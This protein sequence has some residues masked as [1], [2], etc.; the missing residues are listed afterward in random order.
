MTPDVMAEPRFDTDVPARFQVT[1]DKVEGRIE[2]A[3]LGG[4]FIETSSIPDRGDK[5]WLSFEGPDG[6]VVE[7]IG[8]VWWTTLESDTDRTTRQGF[9]VRLVASSGD[10]RRFMKKLARRA[11][12]LPN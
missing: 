4:V 1:A 9:G 12:A 8:I 11:A 3:S 7:A 2:N 6:E 10:Y 5:L